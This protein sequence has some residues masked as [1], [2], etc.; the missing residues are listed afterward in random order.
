M[1][2]WLA[3]TALVVGGAALALIVVMRWSAAPRA[4]A[5]SRVGA[6]IVRLLNDVRARAY[7]ARDERC[8]QGLEA[9]GVPFTF[10]AAPRH[11]DECPFRNVVRM[12]PDGMLRR[13]LFMTCRL[14]TAF[15]RFERDVLQPAAQRH[16]G[17][18]ATHLLENGVRNCRPVAGYDT[19]LSE[20]AFANAID[21]AGVVLQDGSAIRVAGAANADPIHA[22]FLHDVTTRACD[23]FRTVLGPGFDDRHHDHVH[24]DMGMLGGCRP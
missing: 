13:P 22:A 6:P 1:T 14:A 15:V 10:V 20:H 7:F 8:L 2:R 3:F 21:V 16:F 18:P 9:S 19:L 17:Q 11:E 4:L 5:N 24:L 23:V 12:S